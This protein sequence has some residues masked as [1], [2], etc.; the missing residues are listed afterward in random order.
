MTQ[1]IHNILHQI[2]TV[3]HCQI[4]YLDVHPSYVNMLVTVPDGRPS[5]W[6]ARIFKH[7]SDSLL[8]KA[9]NTEDKYWADGFLAQAADRP[10]ST[11]ELK[12]FLRGRQKANSVQ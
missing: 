12:L 8:R 11:A 6:A 1:V 4:D 2:A 3:Y 5:G 9:L 7:H 10:L